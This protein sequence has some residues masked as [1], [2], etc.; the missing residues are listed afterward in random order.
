MLVCPQ[1]DEKAMVDAVARLNPVS[2]A[3]EVV[4]D[5][6]HYKEGVYSRSATQQTFKYL[7]FTN[8]MRLEPFRGPT[9]LFLSHF[10]NI[11]TTI[12]GFSCAVIHWRRS[13]SVL[14]E[15]YERNGATP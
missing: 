15:D 8:N 13:Y 14:E 5:F 3:F 11:C 10:R 7:V 2:F 9:T 4:S 12:M 6:M 1:Y